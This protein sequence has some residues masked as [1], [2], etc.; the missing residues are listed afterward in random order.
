MNLTF[1]SLFSGIGGSD[2][3]AVSTGWD[4]KFWCEIDP[5]CRKVL[6]YWFKNSEGYL[7]NDVKYKQSDSF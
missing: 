5:F 2:I 1:A 3:A 7:E 4:H 6:R